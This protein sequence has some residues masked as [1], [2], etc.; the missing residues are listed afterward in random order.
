MTDWDSILGLEGTQSLVWKTRLLCL[1]GGGEEEHP[2]QKRSSC[3]RGIWTSAVAS[4]PQ[5]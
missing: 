5:L 4:H 2:A 1:G 3:S